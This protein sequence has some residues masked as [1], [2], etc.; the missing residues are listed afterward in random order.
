MIKS[1]W[2]LLIGLSVLVA[3]MNLAWAQQPPGPDRG[4]RRGGEAGR[5]QWRQRTFD[6]EQMRARMLERIQED[7]GVKDE[8]WTALKPLVEDVL[9][10]QRAVQAGSF[11]FFMRRGPGGGPEGPR[12]DDRRPPAG[13]EN[14]EEDAL[15]VALENQETPATEI[16][17]KLK[18]FRAAQ[19]K[20]EKELASA[21]E[22]VR[23]VVTVRQEATLV[24][25]G[26]LK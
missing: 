8:E 16:S 6:P 12:G 1:R 2:L 26:I 22:K 10:K 18:A 24:L 13:T 14:P 19:E 21:R 7:L 17:A 15:R 11:R 9:V 23:E 25:M 4:E 5:E 20:R 3:G